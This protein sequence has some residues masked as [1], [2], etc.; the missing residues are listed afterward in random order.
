MHVVS[1]QGLPRRGGLVGAEQLE[2]RA[3]R[4]DEGQRAIVVD[5]EV[6]DDRSHGRRIL[7]AAGRADAA[8]GV[9]HEPLLRADR[10]RLAEDVPL[11]GRKRLRLLPAAGV[12]GQVERESAGEGSAA[13]VEL[14]GRRQP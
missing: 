5:R 1:G 3:L 2:V 10:Q 13:I 6:Q 4:R 11:A 7:A 9:E 8:F 14:D 12:F